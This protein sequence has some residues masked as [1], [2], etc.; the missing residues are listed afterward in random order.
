[1]VLDPSQATP[2]LIL[3]TE[4][5]VAGGEDRIGTLTDLLLSY[6]MSFMLYREAVWTCVLAKHGA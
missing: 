3:S 6:M 5:E 2:T 1:M 4:T